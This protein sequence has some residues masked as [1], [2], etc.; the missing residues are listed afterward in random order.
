MSG[1]EDDNGASGE[2]GKEHLITLMHP[3]ASVVAGQR[4]FFPYGCT[5]PENLLGGIPKDA[6]RADMLL[7]GCS[8]ARHAL[9]TLWAYGSEC[10]QE[11]ARWDRLDPEERRQQQQQRRQKQKQK[12]NQNQTADGGLRALRFTLNDREPACLARVLLLLQLFFNSYEELVKACSP[13]ATPEDRDAYSARIALCFNAYYN[14]HV[15]N[16]TLHVLQAA[17]NQ[18]LEVSA[19]PASWSRS[20]VGSIAHIAGRHTLDR[21]RYMWC[22]YADTS[23]AQLKPKKHL[24]RERKGYHDDTVSSNNT[25]RIVLTG[26]GP[27]IAA[28]KAMEWGAALTGIHRQYQVW[29]YLDPFPVLRDGARSDRKC[30]TKTNPA[31]VGTDH[32]ELEYEVHHNCNPLSAFH[33]DNVWLS[34][35][36]E[37]TVNFDEDDKD[38]GSS[39]R[40]LYCRP[41]RVSG[42]DLTV[43]RRFVEF[44]NRPEEAKEHIMSKLVANGLEQLSRM[45]WAA[46][47]ALTE[48]EQA[49]ACAVLSRQ[50]RPRGPV[51]VRLNFVAGDAVD[52]CD[53]LCLLSSEGLSA[54]GK[55][56]DGDEPGSVCSYMPSMSLAPCHLELRD[57]DGPAR[58][59]FIDS[60]YLSD[61]LGIL[62][63]VM[64]AS[65]LL[66]PS[67]HAVLRTDLRRS[68]PARKR[69]TR[70]KD[71]EAAIAAQA[72]AEKSIEGL[73][74]K[75][76]KK[77]MKKEARMAA[78]AY[79]ALTDEDWCT[80]QQHQ[81]AMLLG[82]VPVSSI[83]PA[84]GHFHTMLEAA[85]VAKTNKRNAD[86]GDLGQRLRLA[87]KQA[88]L[89]DQHADAFVGSK[90]RRAMTLHPRVYLKPANFSAM[91]LPFWLFMTRNLY[92]EAGD[93][94]PTQISKVGRHQLRVSPYTPASF[95]RLLSH[96]LRFLKLDNS[97]TRQVVEDLNNHYSKGLFDA[98]VVAQLE[99]HMHLLSLYTT[100]D[101]GTTDVVR[102]ALDCPWWERKPPTE[103][104][105]P[106]GAPGMCRVVMIA[107]HE[108]V[109]II[110]A[111]REP[112]LCV[113][114]HD[115]SRG[116]KGEVSKTLISTLHT[117]FVRVHRGTG[118]FP[119]EDKEGAPW[120]VLRDRLLRVRE[121]RPDDPEAELMVS[122]VLSSKTLLPCKAENV[123]LEL[124]FQDSSAGGAARIS[125]AKTL[126]ALEAAEGVI[127]RT[128]LNERGETAVV[129][130]NRRPTATTLERW[131]PQSGK[132]LGLLRDDKGVE[133]GLGQRR[134]GKNSR[135]IVQPGRPE[136]V[137]KPPLGSGQGPPPLVPTRANWAQKEAD[138]HFLWTLHMVN[139]AA[140]ALLIDKQ[141]S[142]ELNILPPCA[143]E[144]MINAPD[145]RERG[146][147]KKRKG[148][149]ED[150]SRGG[151]DGGLRYTVVM[152]YPV[153]DVAQELDVGDDGLTLTVYVHEGV[154]PSPFLNVLQTTRADCTKLPHPL[155]SNW[156]F[157][158][159][160]STDIRRLKACQANKEF[161]DNLELWLGNDGSLECEVLGLHELCRSLLEE[162]MRV[163]VEGPTK[164]GWHMVHLGNGGAGKGG[165]TSPPYE[166]GGKTNVVVVVRM[167]DI[168]VDESNESLLLDVALGWF[169]SNPRGSGQPPGPLE[170]FFNSN[171]PAIKYSPSP[172]PLLEALL[173][174]V[175]ERGRRSYCHQQDCR[176]VGS[177]GPWG[178]SVGGGGGG[179]K[180]EAD[181]VSLCSCG[182]GKD[183]PPA[184][185]KELRDAGFPSVAS[186]LY[187]AVVPTLIAVDDVADFRL[188][189]AAIVGSD[190]DKGKS[191]G[192]SNDGAGD[193]GGEGGGFGYLKD[194]VG[195]S[196]GD[197]LSYNGPIRQLGS[198]V[199]SV[200]VAAVQERGGGV[201]NDLSEEPGSSSPAPA[202]GFGIIESN[203][204]GG[205]SSP[206]AAAAAATAAD[207][208]AGVDEETRRTLKQAGFIKMP[209]TAAEWAKF[210]RVQKGESAELPCPTCQKANPTKICSKCKAVKYCS[211]DCQK[212][213]WRDHQLEC[214]PDK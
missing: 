85:R 133:P 180:N 66:K 80:T 120:F 41:P 197:V 16:A 34:F 113:L 209:V 15:D 210:E 189:S 135:Y 136:F 205:Q 103:G 198:I 161:V 3:Q 52:T 171:Q 36:E 119:P 164:A 174:M 102:W 144:I 155:L 86:I 4:H 182:A 92:V 175:V 123:E 178:R 23:I 145:K 160:S 139:P 48:K 100:E 166:K 157:P 192:E 149:T 207:P 208:L 214:Y 60:S 81:C 127:F 128:K 55:A 95:A 143:I 185:E 38:G 169:V 29:G 7:L 199:E 211:R 83:V 94:L 35:K 76:K 1:L 124:R 13:N 129:F 176:Y 56:R 138:K 122:F 77:K 68:G 72:E 204:N 181:F 115:E 11:R 37:E 101:L 206:N 90:E 105:V 70:A 162:H 154:M 193:D 213:H 202:S 91:V 187:R 22:V 19:S 21:L 190:Q 150:L 24:D 142:F 194:P 106:L 53:A 104:V 59:D 165:S 108:A 114:M 151:V 10:N 87:W 20:P 47:W 112:T 126:K 63:V 64:A 8:D 39:T 49:Q 9:F 172:M 177:S 31:M 32:H 98:D 173:P 163:G 125:V 158:V 54:W 26:E 183:I 130:P 131:L 110:R 146:G 93:C 99:V 156:S 148:A 111:L 188:K 12:E 25:S 40:P 44:E 195:M 89:V 168:L 46:N 43:D 2:R 117:C 152:P 28:P 17:A 78:T 57:L 140:R 200:P 137:V 27:G 184:L 73:D 33:S 203:G 147:K 71:V 201:D 132:W 109:E 45:C 42:V 14:V 116:Q 186:N 170:E 67:P 88:C 153:R 141:T 50:G 212:A 191:K 159:R 75:G 30:Y 79:A 69:L 51:D 118:S 196:G 107:S 6:W 62:N 74:A 96:A 167:Q 179:D 18:L 97:H 5:P 58:F 134:V 61:T 121:A 65:P 84:V 82:V